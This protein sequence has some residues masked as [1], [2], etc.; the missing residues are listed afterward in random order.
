MYINIPYKF[1]RI[2][3]RQSRFM[4]KVH[5]LLGQPWYTHLLCQNFCFPIPPVHFMLNFHFLMFRIHSCKILIFLFVIR[6]QNILFPAL[7]FAKPECDNVMQPQPRRG[8]TKTHSGLANVNFTVR[9]ATR[10]HTRLGKCKYR[11]KCYIIIVIYLPFQHTGL[12]WQ[13]SPLLPCINGNEACGQ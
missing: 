13:W 4:T 5:D 8:D 10:Y 1:H 7:T 9:A 11:K 2:P 3:D 12:K 6:G